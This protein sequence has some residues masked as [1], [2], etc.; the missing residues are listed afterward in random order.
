MLS[1]VHKKETEHFIELSLPICVFY[2]RI[3]S[4]EHHRMMNAHRHFVDGWHLLRCRIHFFIHPLIGWHDHWTFVGEGG[5]GY[6][7]VKVIIFSQASWVRIFLSSTYNRCKIFWSIIRH[8]WFFFQCKILF[9]TRISL[10]AFFLSK[11][12][13]RMFF[14]WNHQYPPQKSNS[15]PLISTKHL[16]SW[17]I[18]ICQWLTYKAFWNTRRKN[19]PGERGGIRLYFPLPGESVRTDLRWRHNQNFSDG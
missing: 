15:R 8:E 9:F 19:C 1:F 17:Q 11:S 14:F 3:F 7:V 10:H 13:S 5:M 2:G 6:L 18:L 4:L 16:L 12:F